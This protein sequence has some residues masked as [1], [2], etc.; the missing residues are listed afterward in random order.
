MNNTTLS[1]L[2]HSIL[3]AEKLYVQNGDK[4]KFVIDC[5]LESLPEEDKEHWGPLLPVLIDFSV[6][7]MKSPVVLGVRKKYGCV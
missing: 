2:Y 4:K 6:S 5:I 7:L 3:K 1:N